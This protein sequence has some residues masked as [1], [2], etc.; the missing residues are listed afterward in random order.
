MDEFRVPKI[1]MLSDIITI[2]D[3]MQFP[4]FSNDG[5]FL[6]ILFI[7]DMLEAMGGHNDDYL[8]FFTARMLLTLVRRPIFRLY[9]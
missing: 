4:K 6:L 1:R 2:R 8:N 9:L 3:N 5:E 7:E